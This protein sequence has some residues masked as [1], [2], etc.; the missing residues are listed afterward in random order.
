MSTITCNIT[1]TDVADVA[2]GFIYGITGNDHKSYLEGCL[3]VPSSL[4]TDFCTIANAAATKDNQQLITA[5]HLITSTDI[6]EMT[7]AMQ[8]CPDALADYQA[9]GGWYKYWKG[10]GTLR[11][12][13]SA[14]TNV[15]HN[16][17]AI[18]AD[19]GI[20]ETDYNANDLYGVGAEASTIAKIALPMPAAEELDW[21]KMISMVQD[22]ITCDISA[23]NISDVAAGFIQGITGNDH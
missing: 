6:P 9:V 3:T 1:N 13:Q 4:L 8:A 16:M 22:G 14:Y 11:V 5:L 23:Q 21:T 12:Y 2:A 17:A 18:K 19:V 7:T 20:I 15:L 10:Q